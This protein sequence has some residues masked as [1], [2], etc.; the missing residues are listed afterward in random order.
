MREDE[1]R[2]RG[3]GVGGITARLAGFRVEVLGEARLHDQPAELERNLV[4]ERILAART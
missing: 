4:R 3:P 1:E 2:G